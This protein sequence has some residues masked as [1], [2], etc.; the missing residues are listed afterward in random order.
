M[1]YNNIDIMA[2]RQ[3]VNYFVF[4][5]RPSNASSSAP[6]TNKDLNNIINGIAEL[7][8]TFIDELGN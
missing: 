8:N 7:F 2:L 5:S 3:A 4:H 1:S 6:C